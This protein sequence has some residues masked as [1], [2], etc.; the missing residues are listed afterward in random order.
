[1]PTW[2]TSHIPSQSSRVALITGVTS[3]IGYE[4]ALALAKKGATVIGSYRNEGKLA[5]AKEALLKACPDAGLHFV[6]LDLTDLH[7]VSACAA[8]VLEKYTRL[9]ILINNAGVMVPP[10]SRT[11]QGFELQIGTNHLG[12]FALTGRLLPLLLRAPDSRIVSV[13]SIAALN[14]KIHI[15]DLNYERRPYNKWEA[16]AQSKL[17]NQLFTQMLAFKLKAHHAATIAT[18]AHPGVSMTELWR[19]SNF[20]TKHIGMPLLS[21]PPDKAARSILRAA[22]DP[23]ATN[24]SYWGPSFL[25][26]RGDPNRAF[27]PR[28]GRDLKMGEK[29]WEMS[30]ALTGVRFSFE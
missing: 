29:L 14:G 10:F 16:Y 7:S 23:D 4:T 9:D 2:N 12:H 27:I 17:A 30:E 21:Q 8:E 6:H 22:C 19:S 26:L 11:K 25:G 5:T 28:R 13:S 1:M 24:G 20:F 3:G 15:N 18:A